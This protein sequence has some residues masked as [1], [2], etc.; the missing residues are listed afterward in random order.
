MGTR[1]A[2]ARLASKWCLKRKQCL[3]ELFIV[4]KQFFFIGALNWLQKQF[5]HW[6]V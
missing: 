1:Q 3:N 4:P 2:S 5:Q 6:T